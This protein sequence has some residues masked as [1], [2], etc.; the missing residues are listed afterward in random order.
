V[1]RQLSVTLQPPPQRLPLDVRHDEEQDARALDLDLPR[2]VQRKDVRVLQL[3][4]DGDLA[5]E[6]RSTDR[7]RE[8]V[9][10]HLEGDL[11]V[12]AQVVREVHRRHAA[13]AELALDAVS[14]GE[15]RR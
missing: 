2:L 1:N 3:G 14:C 4:R 8:T 13:R 6:A 11:A 5:L 10:Q 15:R 9:T 7:R 12:V